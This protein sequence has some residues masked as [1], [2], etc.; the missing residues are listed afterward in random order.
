MLGWILTY[1]LNFSGHPA[2]SVPT[3]LTTDNLPVGM[4]ITG[5]RYGDADVSTASGVL[6]MCDLGSI[7]TPSGVIAESVLKLTLSGIEE[8]ER[9]SLS[10]QKSFWSVG[11]RGS[12]TIMPSASSWIGVSAP[13][14]AAWRILSQSRWR[15]TSNNTRARR[16]LLSSI[17]PR[18]GCSSPG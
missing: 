16:Q 10:G 2:A 14:S 11:T 8:P 1:F 4:Q 6:S 12:L 17:C 5:K 3:G 13:A 7:I 15:H 9:G 18:S